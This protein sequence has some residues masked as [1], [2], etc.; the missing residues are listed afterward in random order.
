MCLFPTLNPLLGVTLMGVWY[1]PN[2]RAVTLTDITRE[3]NGEILEE[4]IHAPFT[5]H[6]SVIFL[7][8]HLL[9]R[10]GRWVVA[11]PHSY[12]QNSGNGATNESR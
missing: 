5:L 2:A 8:V 6:S 12:L 1:L 10:K 11:L 3:T 4:V 7:G 9:L